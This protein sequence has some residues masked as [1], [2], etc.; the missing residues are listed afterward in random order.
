MW[1]CLQNQEIK[2]VQNGQIR[3]RISFSVICGF[4]III[5]LASMM[6]D[7]F[8]VRFRVWSQSQAKFLT[9]A[10]DPVSIS[11]SDFDANNPGLISRLDLWKFVK[12]PVN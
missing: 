3:K 6:H 12:R 9:L 10:D 1:W 8:E 11:K 4:V 2:I 7:W 5:C